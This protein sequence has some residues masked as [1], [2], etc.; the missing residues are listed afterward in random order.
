MKDKAAK[1]A[2]V[3]K[4]KERHAKRKADAEQAAAADA[5][6]AAATNDDTERREKR[7]AEGQPICD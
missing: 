1:E 5:E 2:S 7:K 6:Q 4:T 3:A